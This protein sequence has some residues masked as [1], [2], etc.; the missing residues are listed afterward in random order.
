LQKDLNESQSEI[1]RLKA[2]QNIGVHS[3]KKLTEQLEQEKQKVVTEMEKV[4]EELKKTEDQLTALRK[5]R[6]EDD[7]SNREKKGDWE[8]QKK[9]I[10]IGNGIINITNCC[11]ENAKYFFRK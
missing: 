6:L 8:T 9:K 7:K 1:D 5:E 11:F 2:F 10:P 4:K 3:D